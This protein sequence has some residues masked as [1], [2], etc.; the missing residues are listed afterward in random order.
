MSAAPD[1]LR[2][3]RETYDLELLLCDGLA[4]DALDKAIAAALDTH[5]R[6]VL[7]RMALRAEQFAVDM[8]AE[9]DP[10]NPD[11]AVALKWWASKIRSEFVGPAEVYRPQDDDVVEVMITGSVMQWMDDP[12]L[13]PGDYDW[14][15]LDDKT[16][17]E[18]FF[19][20]RRAPRVR[21]L[22]KNQN[23]VGEQ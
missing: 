2:A 17:R 3:A 13:S 22:S 12:G 21:V 19:E 15:V 7:L 9:Q 18:Y 23:T 11:F 20:T 4:V 5:E 14:S 1:L 10:D 8:E 6:A 16:G